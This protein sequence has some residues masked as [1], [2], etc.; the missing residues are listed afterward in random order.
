M[1]QSKKLTDGSY[2]DAAGVW[3]NNLKLSQE[4]VN[5]SKFDK[6]G[7]TIT[8]N[9]AF[10]KALN[11]KAI[12]GIRNT[13]FF[14][15]P[16]YSFEVLGSTVGNRTEYYQALLKRLCVD[17]PNIEIGMWI[18]SGWPSIQDIAIIHIYGT[19]EKNSTGLPRY[20]RVLAFGV[21]DQMGK[22]FVINN[23]VWSEKSFS[24]T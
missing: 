19:G 20:A 18:G 8:G 12:S 4:A 24:F 7:G 22:S 1:A 9:V 10:S 21:I 15:L 3:D 6:A 16:N 2:I 5:T 17:F 11:N 23:Y 13:N 14:I